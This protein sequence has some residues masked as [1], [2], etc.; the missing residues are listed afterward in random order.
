ME[1][2]APTS[3]KPGF[4]RVHPTFREDQGGMRL[5]WLKGQ[6]S[7]ERVNSLSFWTGEDGRAEQVCG[8]SKYAH[9]LQFPNIESLSRN[10]VY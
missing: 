6:L 3:T 10:N 7:K 5:R 4:P 2:E 1:G 9:V 8:L